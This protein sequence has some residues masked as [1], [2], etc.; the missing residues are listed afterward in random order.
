MEAPPSPISETQ[1]HDSKILKRRK[2]KFLFTQLYILQAI[3][4]QL[5]PQWSS[6]L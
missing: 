6:T 1:K 2:I 4:Q 5:E 3:V